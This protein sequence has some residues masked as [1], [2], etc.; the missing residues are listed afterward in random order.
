MPPTIATR[1]TIVTERMVPLKNMRG[2]LTNLEDGGTSETYPYSGSSSFV[3]DII[4]VS[5]YECFLQ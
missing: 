2:L 5:I 1:T 3:V 4:I